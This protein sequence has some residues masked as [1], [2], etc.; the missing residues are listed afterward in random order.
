MS[1]NNI[2]PLTLTGSSLKTSKIALFLR[3]LNV[4]FT[5]S[6]PN[7]TNDVRIPTLYDPNTN[8]TLFGSIVLVEYLVSNY[9]K[10]D[11]RIMFRRG[12]PEF[13]EVKAWLDFQGTEQGP[14]FEQYLQ[15]SGDVEV[16]EKARWACETL[17]K[18]LNA[19]KERF[20]GEETWLVGEKM[21]FA[22]LSFVVL[23]ESLFRKESFHAG[24]FPLVKAWLGSM[25]KV[26][27]VKETVA[28]I[29]V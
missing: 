6:S 28:E 17:E 13:W 23:Q 25:S 26:N 18:R 8:I 20:A 1:T 5:L 7:T 11:H 14:I 15:T 22:D 24:S 9:D 12:T 3:E 10:D 16:G 2:K 21:S 19:Q 4:P 27:S 29:E